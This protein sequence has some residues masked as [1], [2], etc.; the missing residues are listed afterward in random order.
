MGPVPEKTMLARLGVILYWTACGLAI[1]LVV[2]AVAF[3]MMIT[4]RDIV[5]PIVAV[6]SGCILWSLGL[7]LRYILADR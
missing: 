1:L 7:G 3:E 6:I 4:E 2:L 5:L